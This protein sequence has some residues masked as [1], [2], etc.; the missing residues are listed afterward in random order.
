MSPNLFDNP[1]LY[2]SLLEDLPVGICIVDR[3]H[4]LRFWN[5]GAEHLTGYLAH[6]AMGQ[7]GTGHFLDPCD[8][9]GRELIGDHGP[10]TA[11]LANG[12]AQQF[13]AYLRHKS[14]HRVAVRV[15]TRPVLENIDVIAGAMVLFEEAFAVRDE[16]SGP[17]P[18]YGCLDAP[19]GVPSHRL[20]SAVLN[21]CMA[22]MER[23][24]QGFGL[25]RIRVLEL[26]EFR[27]RHGIQSAF[28]L[29]RTTAQ[30]LRHSLDP[31]IFLGRW[32]EDEFI[33]VLPSANRVTT[34]QAA[35]TV[36]NLVAKSEVS[37]WGDRF[38]V[39]SVVM[40][41]VAQPGD[42]LDKLLNGLEP[43]HAAAAGRAVG[44]T[45]AKT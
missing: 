12:C 32:G 42:V 16:S 9:N 38:S 2:R 39:Q 33:L 29:L 3:Q 8:H 13:S 30:T 21:E 15:R 23:S 45:G 41:T 31:E 14:G 40:Y 36:W 44:P 17:P 11:T 37:W 25:I 27:A 7:D 24:H 19:T 1:D 20:T 18:M 28:P 6:E 10:I 22:G 4:R 5:R 43:A 26:D 34:I 35:E